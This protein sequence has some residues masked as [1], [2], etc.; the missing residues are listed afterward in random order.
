MATIAVRTRKSRKSDGIAFSEMSLRQNASVLEYCR[1][2]I[3]ALSGATAGIMGL[4][5]LWEKVLLLLKA[6]SRWNTFFV[7]RTVLFSNGLLGGLFTYV[8]FWTFLYGMVHVY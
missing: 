4:T 2:S 8:L 1:T 7:T 5:G 6:G 3:S